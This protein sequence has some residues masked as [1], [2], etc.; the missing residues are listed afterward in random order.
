MGW[1]RW[2]EIAQSFGCRAHGTEF[3]KICIERASHKGITVVDYA[4]IP[5]YKYDFINTEQ[6]FEH[7]PNPLETLLHLKKG[8]APDGLLK[9]SVPDGQGIKRRLKTWNWKAPKHSSESLNPVAPLEH[10]NCFNH[11]VLA[12]FALTAGLSI[13]DIR[14]YI[15]EVMPDAD[16]INDDGTYLLLRANA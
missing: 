5:K 10:L 15:A 11:D 4:D 6:V 1:G 2:C 13:V 8:L 12:A 3:N 16:I 14:S 9:I 7:L